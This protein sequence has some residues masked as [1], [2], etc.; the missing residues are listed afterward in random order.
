M[1]YSAL[2]A[3]IGKLVKNINLFG[4]DAS[5]VDTRRDEI[6]DQFESNN[7]QP[8]ISSLFNV[9][10][11]AKSA[12]SSVRSQLAAMA[13]ARLQDND[14][15]IAILNLPTDGVDAV[16][17]ALIADMTANSQTIDASTVTLGTVTAGSGNVGN[18]TA[19]ISKVLDGVTAP[20]SGIT[21]RTAYDGLDSEI[22]LAETMTLSCNSD[23]Y[24]DRQTSGQEGFALY[25]ELAVSDKWGVDEG[26]SGN[27]PT[28]RTANS[29]AI[30][31]NKDFENFTSNAPDNWTIDSGTAGTH[32]F[33]E[34]TNIYRGTYALKFL[35]TGAQATIQLSQTPTTMTPR[36]RYLVSFRYK[37]SAV[38]TNAQFLQAY[39][40][41]TGYTAASS[42]KV[43]IAGDVWSTSW[44]HAYFWINVPANMPSDWAFILRVTGTPSSGKAVYIDS[45]A[46]TPAVY[47][48][49]VAVGVIA[50]STP[51]VRGDSF[52]WTVANDN[53]GTFQKFFRKQ[54]GVQLPSNTGGSETIA[55]SL[56]E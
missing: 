41:G 8:S 14:T 39:F 22:S 37:A 40:T 54:F 28:V 2:F 15:V 11:S 17:T 3:D 7:Q 32:I 26:G 20:A 50:G 1:D 49:G 10:N 47:H 46:V 30:L 44:A 4:T 43:N 52:T 36:K 48:N 45:L 5:D 21:A 29:S 23:S 12:L 27:G 34:S 31:S 51:F 24:T 19:V 25:G 35:G 33:R 56:A 13:S 38:D 42:E 16:L 55:D 53:A 6:A 9:A 18:G